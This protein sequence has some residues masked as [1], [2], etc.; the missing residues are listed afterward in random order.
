M[1]ENKKKLLPQGFYDS[2]D[3]TAYREIVLNFSIIEQLKSLGYNLIKPSIAEFEEYLDSN[4]SSELFKVTDPNSGKMMVI[5]NDITPQIARIVKDR[6]IERL[7]L[8]PEN[9]LKISYTGQV[10]KRAGKGKYQ[11]RQITQ[12]GFELVGGSNKEAD[13]EVLKTVNDIFQSLELKSYTIDFSIP[14][15]AEEIFNEIGLSEEDKEI[16]QRNIEEKNIP[17]LKQD[18]KFSKLIEIINSYEP[19]TSPE[20]GIVALDKILAIVDSVKS[21]ELL[22]ELKDLLISCRNCEVSLNLL[23]K[24]NFS[25]H[26]GV[27]FS[28]ISQDSYEE[29]GRGGRYKI[30][31]GENGD[32]DAI[33][34]T[35]IL[36]SILR[37][38]Q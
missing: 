31:L 21:K 25:Y 36:N 38:G 28:V 34:F 23:E 37:M 6:Y 13:I 8:S 12:T 15:L 14:N 20:E 22:N 7:R 30:S 9:T 17:A 2:L 16:A 33:G 24:D 11:E 5:R 32:V 4:F 18:S 35:F 19:S 10:F 1:S 3:K 27:C 29:L 26:T